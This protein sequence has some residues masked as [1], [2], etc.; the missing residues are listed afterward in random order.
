MSNFHLEVIPTLVTKGRVWWN[1]EH[2]Q[3]CQTFSAELP[4]TKGA[5]D[6]ILFINYF[7]PYILTLISRQH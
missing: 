6:T 4:W 5:D 3:T 2:T 1:F 7:L